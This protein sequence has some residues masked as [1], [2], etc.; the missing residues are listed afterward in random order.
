VRILL[1]STYEMGRQPFGLASPAAW[2]RGEG[3]SVDVIDLSR[4]PLAP[5]LVQRADGIA[6]YLPMHTATVLALEL[7]PRLR[8]LNPKGRLAAYGLYA[9]VNAARLRQAGVDAILGGEFEQGLVR[10]ARGDGAPEVSLE[11]QRFVVPDRSGLPAP[12]RYAQ[13]Q[14]DGAPRIAGYTEATRGCKHLCR[15][16]P[17]VPV[18]GG[19]F[20]IV[21]RDVVLADIRQQVASGAEH[22]TF[23]DPDFLNGPGHAIALVEALH[24]EFPRLTYDVTIKIEHLLRHRALLPILK[25]TGCAFVTSAVESV[26]DAVLERFAKNHTRADFF[27]AVALVREVGLPL[28]PTFVAF[29]PWT[30]RAGYCELLRTVADLGLVEN[31]A[32]VQYAIR[33]LVPAGSLLIGWLDLEPFD[34]ARLVYP[35]RHPDA[36]MDRLAGEI[37]GIAQGRGSRREI[38]EQVWAAAHERSFDLVLADRATVPYLNEPWYC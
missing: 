22:I 2:L 27:T 33:L 38:F 35:W 20:R 5:D 4:D 29:T 7:L 9:P 32:P 26:D 28:S 31:V 19:A 15:H 36:G 30:T 11:R 12:D 34:A 21:Q 1:L 8:R 25:R 24:R 3:H 17:V 16:C 18:Y 23:G 14:G 6:L 10:W 37:H 13:V